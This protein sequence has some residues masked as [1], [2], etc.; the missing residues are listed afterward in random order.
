MIKQ[1]FEWCYKA[2]FRL[3]RKH[4]MM[5]TFLALSAIVL[6]LTGRQVK[7]TKAHKADLRVIYQKSAQ[8]RLPDRNPVIVIPG[9][10]GSKL[11]DQETNQTIW[12]AFDLDYADPGTDEGF[13][14]IAL[15]IGPTTEP[16]TMNDN[17]VPIGVLDK[18]VI[19]VLGI[20]LN[21]QAYAGIL[22]TLGVGG[23]RDEAFGKRKAIDYGE[24]HYTCFQFAYDW[25]RSNAENAV[26]F[27]KFLEQ[28]R[29]QIQLAYE[30]EYGIKDA[31][32]KFDVVAHSMGGLMTR[33]FLRYG[34][35]D[36]DKNFEAPPLTWEGS[37]YIERAI[38]VGTPNAGA[39]GA[40]IQLINGMDIGRPILPH[41][42]PELVGTFPSVYELLPRPR[43]GGIAWDDDPTDK[44][45]NI[46][47]PEL[48]AENGWG[49]AQRDE[50]NEELLALL[51]PDVTSTEERRAIA[52]EYQAT[53]LKRAEAFHKAL[54][55]PA[56]LPEG[57]E[58]FLVAGDAHKKTRKVVSIEPG[59]SEIEVLEYG[60]G[61][62][63]V[64]RSSALMDERMGG[65]WTP[66]LQTPIDWTSVMFLFAEHTKI[67]QDPA[68][69]DNV[70]FWLMEDPRGEIH[71]TQQP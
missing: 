64:L 38:L 33:Y 23:Y 62:G 59:N 60:S 17:V 22:S 14:Q 61:D 47:D 39:S 6:F 29:E 4:W 49:L 43:H 69:T 45:E 52:L 31:D 63:V 16:S 41:Y 53:L 1:T 34:P 7:I 3:I 65:E 44:V 56:R 54:D 48:W 12:G 67:T 13:V 18:M 5:S 55:R 71:S 30:L 66:H 37:E 28:K 25:R 19:N 58:L 21:I 15:P 51:L 70:L 36:I 42:P 26:R 50:T 11:I 9:V 10:L 46:Y 68:F 27:H 32:V 24:G 2:P 8:V 35:N 57:L 20:P 40:F